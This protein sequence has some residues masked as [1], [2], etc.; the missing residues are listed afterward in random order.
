MPLQDT[1]TLLGGYDQSIGDWALGDDR[2]FSGAVAGLPI[3][4]PNLA[5][6]F[7]T[8]KTNP[9]G[10]DGNAILQKRINLL[11]QPSGIITPPASLLIHVFSGDYE[12]FVSFG[13]A[14]WWDFRITTQGGITLTVAA[15]TVQFRRNVT[16]TNASGSPFAFPPGG[17]GMPSFRGFIADNPNY[18]VGYA[19]VDVEGDFYFN[20]LP[21]SGAPSGWQCIFSGSPGTWRSMGIVGD[22]VIQ[23]S[24][25][26]PLMA[27][28]GG[29]VPVVRGFITDNPNNITGYNA[30]DIQGDVFFNQTPASGDPSGWQ[31][32]TGGQPGVWTTMGIV[33]DD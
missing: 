27:S 15:G 26:Q 8:L 13:P 32:I 5:Q 24:P 9:D 11:S 14:Y 2:I 22:N 29:G 7:F 28:R 21:A 20:A 6:A 12:Q 10:A 3:T 4:D 31:C 1:S 23:P 33:G 18:I 30:V 19:L 16:Q 17:F 25:S